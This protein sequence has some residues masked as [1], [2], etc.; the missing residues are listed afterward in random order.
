[1]IGDLNPKKQIWDLLILLMAI[2][3]S[4]AVPLEYVITELEENSSYQMIDLF[5]NILFIFDIIIGF[6]TTY[7]DSMGNEIKSP[8]MVAK[9]YIK[10][11][12]FIDFFSSIPYRYIK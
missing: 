12:F 11:M 6:R 8:G 5:I 10:G 2:F 1:M 4:F 9:K 3:N 7:F